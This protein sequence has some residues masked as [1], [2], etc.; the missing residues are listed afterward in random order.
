[1]EEHRIYERKRDIDTKRVREFYE[2]RARLLNQ[3]DVKEKSA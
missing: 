3:S 2:T 1:M